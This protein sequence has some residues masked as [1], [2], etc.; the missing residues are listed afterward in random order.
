MLPVG[1]FTCLMIPHEALCSA[2]LPGPHS[3]WHLTLHTHC[4]LDPPAVDGLP[5]WVQGVMDV[6]MVLALS[7]T[8]TQEK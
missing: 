5:V 1:M 3:V 8:H 4:L 6:W 7:R 2:H